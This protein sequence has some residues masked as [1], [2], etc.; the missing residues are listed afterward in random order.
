LVFW[1]LFTVMQLASSV[2]ILLLSWN[3]FPEGRDLHMLGSYIFFAA[4]F[5]VVIIGG[6]WC[7]TL[8]GKTQEW[9]AQGYSRD[10]LAR[11]GRLYPLVAV[12]YPIYLGLF[13]GKDLVP[14][15]IWPLVIQVYVWMELAVISASLLY[16]LL[17]ALP[18]VRVLRRVQP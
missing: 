17:V 7:R 16:C 4:Q 11:L 13:V 3:R 10:Y 18:A 15:A 9:R 14:Q 6:L 2:G 1:G 12:L 8:V 5:L